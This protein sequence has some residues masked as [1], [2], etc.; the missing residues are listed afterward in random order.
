MVKASI[1]RQEANSLVGA[2]ESG[3]GSSSYRHT[4]KLARRAGSRTDL[5][6]AHLAAV[7]S[8][9]DDII[10]S[11]TLEGRIRSWNGAATRI[12]GYEAAEMIGEPITRIIPPELHAEEEQILGRLRR[13]ERIV[14][15]ETVR[16]TKDGRR[17]DVSLSVS[18]IRDRFGTLIGASKVARD[19][20]ERKQH[21]KEQQVML[22]ELAHRSKNLLAV[23]Q[24]MVRQTALH[25]EEIEEF[26]A[27]LDGRISSLSDAN[28]LLID[29]N[30]RGASVEDL[31]KAQLRPFVDVH[32]DRVKTSGPFILLNAQATQQL[33][34]A[35]HELATNACKYGA[36]S[37]T[38]GT[39][40]VDWACQPGKDT[41]KELWLRWT[42]RG[43]PAV[44]GNAREGFGTLVLRRLTPSGL[45][46]SAELYYKPDGFEWILS[47]S[48]ASFC[49]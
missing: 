26:R 22:R 21:E 24:A 38:D 40:R 44:M 37:V 35:L 20:T 29:Q 11:K 47:S 27:Q 16:I 30:W 43:G 9:S 42:E 14:H 33:A 19:I 45:N 34:L 3:K 18:P 5:E 28:D 6:L 39:V 41:K 31:I 4:S 48:D 7:V 23:V 46:G 36:L 8:S 10:I 17:V 1:Q 12:L 13:G 32:S 25:A 2:R 15:F 49:C